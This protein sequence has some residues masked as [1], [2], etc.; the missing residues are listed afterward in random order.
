MRFPHLFTPI[1]VLMLIQVTGCGGNASEDKANAL[2]VEY[3]E[4][5]D[6]DKTGDK[7]ARVIRELQEIK[8]PLSVQSTEA[9]QR[10]TASHNLAQMGRALGKIQDPDV[11]EQKKP[12]ADAILPLLDNLDASAEEKKIE[13]LIQHIGALKD[14]KF[15]R[16]G[17]EYDAKSAAKFLRGKWDAHR[18]DVKTAEDFIAKVATVSGTSGAPYRLRFADAKEMKSGD[19]LRA[20]LAKLK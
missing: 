2:L 12:F 16:N 8:G 7:G 18:A 5:S 4:L 3:A 17:S 13:A 9:I 6:Q 15:I 19:Y 10:V 14:V 20:E 1:V 11:K